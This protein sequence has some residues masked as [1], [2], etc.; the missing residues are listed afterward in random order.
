[1]WN[2]SVFFLLFKQKNSEDVWGGGCVK[3]SYDYDGASEES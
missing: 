2:G 1:M 3:L